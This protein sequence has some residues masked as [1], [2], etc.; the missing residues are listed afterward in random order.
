[1]SMPQY[2]LHA[3]PVAVEEAVPVAALRAAL[4]VFLHRSEEAAREHGLTP[5][6]HLLLLLIKGAP[7]HSQQSTVMELAERM[8]LAQSSVTEL[9]DRAVAADLVRR[10][11][12]LADGRV[13]YLRL[14][15]TGEERLAAVFT[16]LAEERQRLRAA[17]E[18]AQ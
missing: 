3:E 11:H 7:D 1:M 14:T 5:R 2:E 16:G 17:I 15:D 12:S 6:Q 4:R 10:H 9:V 18:Q 13:S 8:Q